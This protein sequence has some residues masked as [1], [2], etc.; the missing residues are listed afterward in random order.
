[1]RSSRWVGPDQDGFTLQNLDDGTY[2][3][4]VATVN[5]QGKQEPDNI[6][7]ASDKNLVKITIQRNHKLAEVK[8]GRAVIEFRTAV[9]TPVQDPSI[10]GQL[11]QREIVGKIVFDLDRGRI[12]DPR[13]LQRWRR[14]DFQRPTPDHS[15]WHRRDCMGP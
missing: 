12:R 8:E 1:M 2:W 13:A 4:R 9:L 15:Q 5:R 3:L 6:F 10:A 14:E 7:Q 11:I